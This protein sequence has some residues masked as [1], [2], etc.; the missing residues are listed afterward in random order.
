MNK[1]E[2]KMLKIVFCPRTCIH[3]KSIRPFGHRVAYPTLI[4]IIMN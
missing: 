4:K 2:K 3:N 1:N